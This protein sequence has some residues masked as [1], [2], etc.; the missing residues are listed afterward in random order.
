[1]KYLTIIFL[2]NTIGLSAQQGNMFLSDFLLE[3]ELKKENFLEKY[4]TTD[5]S[6][7]WTQTANYRI[8]GMIGANHQ[9]IRIALLSISQNSTVPFEYSVIGKSKVKT[10]ICDFTGTI[11]IDSVLEVSQMHYGVDDMY[12]DSLLV[13]Q[14]VV[15]ATYEFKESRKQS[16]SGVFNGQLMT[17]WYINSKGELKY[18]NIQSMSDGF[19]NN[20]FVGTWTQYDLDNSKICNWADGRIPY[21]AEDFDIGAGE[22]LP[23]KKYYKFGWKQYQKAW[24]YG[25]EKAKKEEL[26]KW[27]K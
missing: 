22:F 15:F 26:S 8:K 1:M 5:I 6:E 21:S 7:L 11:R 20:T 23:S 18:D 3:D 10:N 14:G 27:W 25:D 2:F 17:K 9:R 13:A 12:K 19:M 16:H 24:L 4:Q